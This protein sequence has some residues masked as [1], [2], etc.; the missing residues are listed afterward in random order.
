MKQKSLTVSFSPSAQADIF[1]VYVVN[2]NA[3]GSK[4]EGIQIANSHNSATH[5]CSIA[6]I[7]YSKK[8]PTNINYFGD[9]SIR[10]QIWN[11]DGSAYSVMLKDV[12][13]PATTAL[14]VLQIP[15]FL[16]PRDIITLKPTST[17]SG[18]VFKPTITVTEYFEDD[19]DAT[20]TVDIYSVFSQV[21]SGT[22]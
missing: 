15:V 7:E 4:V 18:A 9:G 13:I 22:Y 8:Y 19:A 5:T 1:P 16:R 21:L 20:T 11:Y 3:V 12:S 6:R 10:S 17:G 14:N 2:P